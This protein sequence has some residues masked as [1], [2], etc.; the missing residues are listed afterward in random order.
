M[1]AGTD[2]A[3]KLDKVAN[4]IA[5]KQLTGDDPTRDGELMREIG[6]DMPCAKCSKHYS[7]WQ[8]Q[9][10]FCDRL[11]LWLGRA[12]WGRADLPAPKADG[13]T[14]GALFE[15]LTGESFEDF[16]RRQRGS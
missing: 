12:I 15:R 6:G 2:L 4:R 13:L 1:N 10:E 16:V 5:A 7:A 3:E 11:K 14:W 9:A 8:K